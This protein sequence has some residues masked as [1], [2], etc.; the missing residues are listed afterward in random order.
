[1]C[2][3]VGVVEADVFE[4]NGD[5]CMRDNESI[6]RT[7]DVN[8]SR[9]VFGIGDVFVSGVVRVGDTLAIGVDDTGMDELRLVLPSDDSLRRLC[10]ESGRFR[11]GEVSLR[12]E[13]GPERP[14]RLPVLLLRLLF[15]GGPDGLRGLTKFRPVGGFGAK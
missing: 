10:A 1:M 2:E 8:D 3:L 4:C 6:L 9:F 5:E 13:L 7:R 11:L 14:T 15:D 12:T